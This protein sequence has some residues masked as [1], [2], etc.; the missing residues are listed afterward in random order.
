VSR[1]VALLVNPTSGGGRGAAEGRAAADRLRAL[2]IGV[3]LLE[4]AGPSDAMRLAKDAVRAGVD[5]LVVAGGDGMVHLGVQ[6]VAGTDV[7]LGFVPAGTG[8]D[9]A[10]ALG[11]PAHDPRAASDIV[12]QW[13]VRDVDAVLTDSAAGQ[14]WY[15]G[16]MST[17]FDSAVNERANAMRWPRGRMRYN[18]GIL[19]ELGVFHALPFRLTIDGTVIEVEAMLAAVGNNTRYGGGM[20]IAPAALLDDGLLNVTVLRRLGKIEFLRVFPRVYKGTHVDHPAVEVHV[21][22]Q[23][24]LEAPGAIAYAD[25]ERIGG[26]PI[27]ATCVPGA[28]RVLAP[29]PP[30]GA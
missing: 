26:L 29:P 2:G 15:A 3:R 21:G 10:T 16:V 28:L 11:I 24:R 22:R 27:T 20:M 19:A 6:Y 5:A 8:N 1:S 13:V 17:G 12:A 25:G 18:L 9:F 4:G 7:P 30:P 23:V 14:R